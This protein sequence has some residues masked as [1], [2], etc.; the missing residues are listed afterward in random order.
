MKTAGIKPFRRGNIVAY[1]NELKQASFLFDK[2]GI[3][4]LTPI[5]ETSNDIWFKS[6]LEH[7]KERSFLFEAMPPGPE[8]LAPGTNLIEVQSHLDFMTALMKKE[9]LDPDLYFEASARYSA[10][11]LN[12]KKDK[13]DFVSFPILKT[14]QSMPDSNISSDIIQIAIEKIPI[15]DESTPWEK[16]WDFKSDTNNI[17]K[18]A[19]FRVWINELSK[20]KMS[21]NEIRDLLESKLY[22]Y[23]Q[24]LDL[25]KIKYKFGFLETI[26]LATS[27]LI[28]HIS[29]F[30]GGVPGKV[31]FQAKQKRIDLLDIEQNSKGRELAYFFSIQDG[32]GK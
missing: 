22:E 21:L 4:A 14:L 23:R 20:S 30:K 3:P 31:L 12:S 15:P 28:D 13:P 17:G 16:V 27:E 7:L 24:S 9:N 26:L 32:F 10:L 11:I 2:I 29:P 25:H 6:E 18:L 8:I 5:L 19:N 1:I